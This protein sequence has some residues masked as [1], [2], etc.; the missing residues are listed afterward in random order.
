MA[1]A[2]RLAGTDAGARTAQMLLC[3]VLGLS[4][5]ALAAHDDEA[6][7]AGEE[8][9]LEELLARRLA[10]E[11]AAYVLGEKEFYGRDLRV[12]RST[13][14]PRPETEDL[15]DAALAHFLPDAAVCFADLG[16]GSGCIAV[17]L[18]AERP[19]WSGTALDI[20]PEALRVA[21]GNAQR[22]GVDARIR[23]LQADFAAPLPLP[24][25]KFDLVASNPP[26]VSEE[27]YA[28]LDAVVRGYEPR[29]A[30]VPGPTGLELAASVVRRAAE[31][32]RPGGLLLM[33]H[34]WRQGGACR[35][36]CRT[37]DWCEAGTGRDLAGRERFL[38]AVRR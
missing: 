27:E 35:A 33:E 3:H 26:Y 2:R 19:R 24:P 31:L 17:T 25:G 23:F 29:G 32:L 16:T 18:A 20:S 30:L 1:A 38:R 13:L 11:P 21:Q 5:E 36:L 9:R 34:G 22:H 4:R 12:D 28:G 6:L 7:D 10:G 37:E 15:V 14:I 8:A